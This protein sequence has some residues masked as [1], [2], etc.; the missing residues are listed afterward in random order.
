TA[1]SRKVPH[2]RSA[3]PR[4]RP[5][6]RSGHGR[7][8]PRGGRGRAAGPR[9][10]TAGECGTHAR[11][12]SASRPPPAGSPAPVAGRRSRARPGAEPRQLGFDLVEEGV[13]LVHLV[14]LAQTDGAELLVSDV[15]GGQRHVV[16]S[17]C[18][19]ALCSQ[20]ALA[21]PKVTGCHGP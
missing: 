11:M 5:P 16:T 7:R 8:R 15:L 18:R 13:D 20:S 14:A 12:P 19:N 9:G 17:G 6:R 10:K 1:Y 4:R 2:L 21:R 3:P